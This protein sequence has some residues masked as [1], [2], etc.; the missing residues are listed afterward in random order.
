MSRKTSTTN[1]RVL[2]F[3]LKDKHASSLRAMAVEVNLVWN[4]CNELSMKVLERE[5]RFVG[6]FELQSY[7]NGASKEG[8]KVGSAVFQQVADEYAQKRKQFKK[9]KLRWR[10]SNPNRSN[11]SLGWIPFKARSLS[12]KGG[13]VTFQS[14]KLSLWDSYGL[15]GRKLGA[16][17]ISEDSRGRW[18]LN[19]CVEV[20]KKV[21]P[22][23]AEV[24]DAVGIDLG[25]KSLMTDSDG[26]AV[27]AQQFYRDLEPAIASAQRAGKKDR[28][29][30]LHDKVR[31]RRKDFLHKLSTKQVREHAAL[32][33]GNVNSS[34]LAK[35][36]MAKSVLDAGWSAY[37]TMLKYKSDDAGA[38]FK[39]VDEKFSTQDCSVCGS[40]TG[41]KGREGLSVRCW[42]CSCCS[43]EHDRDTNAAQNIK[44]KG[45]AWLESEFSKAVEA[46]AK[47]AA[48]NEASRAT[49]VKAAPGHGRPKVG[50]SVL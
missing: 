27:A 45:L 11:Y 40:R 3:R 38:W 39:E 7:L 5:R 31:N 44:L 34:A 22:T 18:Y 17:S 24:K 9:V 50:I 49:R 30:A 16:G 1:T 28:V 47:D 43:T 10:V 20:A 14:L 33:V 19:V 23:Q 42:T 36:S 12:Y 8:L 25:L 6:G 37:R 35:T 21:L 2:R 32:F 29:R 4:F 48:L 15:A 41:P 13:Q 46:Q 26:R